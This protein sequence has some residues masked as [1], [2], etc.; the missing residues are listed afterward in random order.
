MADRYINTSYSK[1]IF[2]SFHPPKEELNPPKKVM[3]EDKPVFGR[4]IF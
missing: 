4:L 3:K 1:I 2:Q